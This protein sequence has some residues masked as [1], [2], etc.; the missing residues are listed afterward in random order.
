[1]H[2]YSYTHL[3]A[4]RLAKSVLPGCWRNIIPNTRRFLSEKT[5][6]QIPPDTWPSYLCGL[7]LRPEAATQ[8]RCLPARFKYIKAGSPV[9]IVC[10]GQCAHADM[11]GDFQPRF[12]N[13]T[14]SLSTL[15]CR[16]R[17]HV[18]E[19]QQLFLTRSLSDVSWGKVRISTE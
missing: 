19:V 10:R 1:M 13:N 18:S 14:L 17:H 7:L 6:L 12:K 3:L 4:Y 9:A 11:A 5:S 8:N 2:N 15:L 16:R